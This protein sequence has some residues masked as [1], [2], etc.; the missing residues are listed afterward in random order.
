MDE[1]ARRRRLSSRS[2]DAVDQSERRDVLGQA[3]LEA[4]RRPGRRPNRDCTDAGGRS[5]KPM[6]ADFKPMPS[7]QPNDTF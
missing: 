2:A 5:T 3:K 7:I 4:L 1:G 6:S